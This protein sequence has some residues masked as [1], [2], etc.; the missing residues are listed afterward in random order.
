[1]SLPDDW[2][3]KRTELHFHLAEGKAAISRM[4]NELLEKGYITKR[5]YKEG[6]LKRVEYIVHEKPTNSKNVFGDPVFGL[7]KSGSRY[8]NTN[9]KIPSNLPNVDTGGKNPTPSVS[10]RKKP[11]VEEKTE[12]QETLRSIERWIV[13]GLKAS[14]CEHL[15][16]SAGKT[17]A[18]L[19]ISN[20][21]IGTFYT[22]SQTSRAALTLVER[23]EEKLKPIYEKVVGRPFVRFK[24]FCLGE[25]KKADPLR[26]T[27]RKLVAE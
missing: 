19:H 16:V 14:T 9:N 13:E 25:K 6:N 7:P 10:V 18:S 5:F 11:S 8:I 21:L 23:F 1:L 24:D 15:K 22:R 4:F 17:R 27:Q 2:E 3:I 20:Q 12:N 26:S